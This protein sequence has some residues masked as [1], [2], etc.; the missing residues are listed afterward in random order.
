MA[1]RKIVLVTG[2]NGGIGYEAVKALLQSTKPYH[3]FLGSRSPEKAITA[4]ETLHK[5]CP[6][7]KNT[8]EALQV[9]LNSD[10]SIQ[11]AFEQ[12]KKS[13]G[14]ID[15]LVNNAGMYDTTG[16]ESAS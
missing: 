14:Y 13:P 8:V 11:R 1:S 4:I 15:T 7:T 16:C 2:A 6:E 10:D 5:E 3:V 12:V 9:D